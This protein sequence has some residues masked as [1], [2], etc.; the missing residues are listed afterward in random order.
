MNNGERCK[1]GIDVLDRELNG[2]F[3]QGATIIVAGGAGVGKT[4]L[5]MEFL[6]N[7]VKYGE[8]NT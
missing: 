4:T 2:G 8:Y 3:P 6:A 1:T 7:G 5:C